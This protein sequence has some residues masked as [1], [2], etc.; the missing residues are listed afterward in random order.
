[1]KALTKIQGFMPY[2]LI[3]FLNAFVDLG[4]KILIQNTIFKMW[5]GQAQVILTAIIN[6]MILLPFILLFSPSGFLSDRYS[7]HKI[8][9]Y[10]ALVA[11]AA[12]LLITLA[13]SQGWFWL[14]FGLT[15]LLAMQSA[16]YSPAKYGYI[17]EL[18]GDEQLAEGNAVVQAVTIIAILMGTFVFSALFE[19]LIPD[20]YLSASDILRSLVGLG[21]LLVGLSVVEYWISHSL[22]QKKAGDNSQRFSM[23]PFVKGQYLKANLKSIRSHKTIW[24]SI[25]GLSMFWAI[26]QVVLASFPAYAKDVLSMTNTVYIQ[27]LLACT[28]IG[29]LLGSLVAGKVS[30]AYIE[31]GL[32]PV[33]AIGI[34]LTLLLLPLM[35]G[36]MGLASVFILLGFFGGLF[37]VP[38]NALIQYTADEDKMGTI[39]AGNN[40]V[41]NVTMLSF[42][43]LTVVLASVGFDSVSLF[44]I[45]ALVAFVGAVYTVKTLPHSLARLVATVLFKQRYKVQVEGFEN[46]PKE[47]GV[48]LLGNHMS[49]IDWAFIQ[50][51][52]PRPLRFV[53]LRDIYETW[54]LKP[55]FKFFGAIPISRGKSKE[56]LATVNACLKNGEVVC[57]F[58]EGAISTDG[59][60]AEFKTGYERTVDGVDGVIIPFHLK[61][62][63]GS[64]FSK[65]KRGCPSVK[66]LTGFKRKI[67]VHFGKA[68]PMD[69]R[70]EGLREIVSK[71]A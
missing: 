22:K 65:S 1:M 26:S 57:L 51:T 59:Q 37:I 33:A 49:F 25:V 71:L 58:P 67:C 4:H 44:Y 47:G 63:W 40:W 21:W 64:M 15:L 53:M 10:G 54:Y 61:G 55:V 28:G 23:K 16:I 11:V 70:A 13:Y 31:I 46:L 32:I 48:L 69:T 27:G 43:I 34:A 56:A 60:M 7:K 20:Q 8:I 17:R 30:K 35:T 18:L 50:M 38:L 9:Q 42:L 3:V 24:L 52:C 6:A 36:M 62:L 66:K 14:A 2:I 5:D 45:L 29:I 39:L 12:T 68:L 19:M 41:Q